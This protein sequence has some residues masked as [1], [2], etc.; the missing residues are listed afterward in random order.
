[1]KLALLNPN[2]QIV[3]AFVEQSAVSLSVFVNF[4]E[5]RQE[6]YLVTGACTEVC[7]QGTEDGERES[8]SFDRLLLSPESD[9]ERAMLHEVQFEL[10]DKDQLW[11][12]W[13]KSTVYQGHGA[14]VAAQVV[15]QQEYIQALRCEQQESVK[16]YT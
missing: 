11:L 16:R 3:S 7:V 12:I 4:R 6:Y 10:M 14:S 15:S 13:L 1:M 5:R 9:F 2:G 8:A